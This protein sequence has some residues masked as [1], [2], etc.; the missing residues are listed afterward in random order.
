[1]Y[2]MLSSSRSLMCLA[3]GLIFL[4]LSLWAV[5]P[6][7]TDTSSSYV[8]HTHD[9]KPTHSHTA[10]TCSAETPF[11]FI[12]ERNEKKLLLPDNYRFVLLDNPIFSIERPPESVLL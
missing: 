7:Y 4:S 8:M 10:D 2:P 11:K 5:T 6:F 12:L 1:M 9:G 3:M